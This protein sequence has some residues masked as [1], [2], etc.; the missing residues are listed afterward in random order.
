M[1]AETLEVP[2]GC[3]RKA[4]WKE[5]RKKERTKKI[6]LGIVSLATLSESALPLLATTTTTTQYILRTSS[7]SELCN[8]YHFP[9]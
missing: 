6:E 8:L 3:A 9:N 2:V 5:E 1:P 4:G 7:T